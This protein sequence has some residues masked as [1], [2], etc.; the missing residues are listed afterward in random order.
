MPG[1]EDIMKSKI[2]KM[3]AMVLAGAL[4][5][6]ALAGCAGTQSAEAPKPEANQVS[7]VSEESK[8]AEPAKEEEAAPKN[9]SGTVSL[10]G[11]TSM[12]KVCEALME[13]FMEMYPEITVTT[14]YTGSGAGLES[15]NAGSVDI[16]NASRHVKDEEAS[17]GAVE[18]VI[19]LDG[20]AVIVD[21]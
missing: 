18:N 11:S 20:I 14:E 2:T 10:A 15:L 4:S 1:R 12:E 7:A 9:L 13:G 6:A 8:E 16:G 17:N 3:L 21:K 19:A 5:M